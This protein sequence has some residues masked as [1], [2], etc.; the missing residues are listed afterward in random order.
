MSFCIPDDL[1]DDAVVLS[2]ARDY[3]NLVLMCN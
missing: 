3:W 2:A 1:G